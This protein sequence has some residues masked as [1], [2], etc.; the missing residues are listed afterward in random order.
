M[1]GHLAAN[2]TTRTALRVSREAYGGRRRRHGSFPRGCRWRIVVSWL[3]VMAATAACVQTRVT[4]ID[5]SAPRQGPVSPDSVRILTSESEL[6][7]L[8]YVRIAIIEATGS[9]EYTNQSEMIEAM[10]KRAAQLGAN[11]ILL[12]TIQEPSAGA[13]VAAAIFGVGTER[14][15]NAIAIL[16]RGPKQRRPVPPPADPR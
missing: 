3:A 16:I 7:T 1:L 13:K 14:K 11:A 10:R 9:G 8:D 4:L 2:A 6:D 5:P 15:G 12:P